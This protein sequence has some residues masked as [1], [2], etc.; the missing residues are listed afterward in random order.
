MGQGRSCVFLLGKLLI[1]SLRMFIKG[2]NPGTN[3]TCTSN[4]KSLFVQIIGTPIYCC[5]LVRHINN[6]ELGGR[7]RF[8]ELSRTGISRGK[9]P[10]WWSPGHPRSWWVIKV[11]LVFKTEKCTLSNFFP[12]LNSTGSHLDAKHTL[13]LVPIGVKSWGP[14]SLFQL[15]QKNVE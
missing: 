2:K 12:W 13:W 15:K 10:L 11:E 3:L 9:S 8:S 4:D 7:F 6:I 14:D 1:K 5:F